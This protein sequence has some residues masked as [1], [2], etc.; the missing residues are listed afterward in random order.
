M[1]VKS[2]LKLAHPRKR[3]A[4]DIAESGPGWILLR[5]FEALDRAGIRYCMLH[6]YESYPQRIGSDVDC[7]IDAKTAPE[8][9]YT[10]LHQNRGRIGAE[11]VRCRGYHIVLAGKNADGSPVF[12][13][14]DLSPDC[15]LDDVRFYAGSEVLA[16][17]RRY[18]EF[19]IPAADIEFGCYLARTIAKANLDDERARRLSKLYGQDPTRCQQQAARFWGAPNTEII[20]AAAQSNDWKEVRQRLA[21]LR[22]ELLRRAILRHLGRFVGNKARGLIDR[23]K[24]VWQPAGLNVVL[25]GPDGAGKSSIIDALAPML[26]GVFPRTTCSGFA[27]A[28]HRLLRRGPRRTDQPHALPARSFMTSVLRAGYWFVYYSFS[29]LNIRLSLARSTLVLNDRHFVDIF[30]DRKRYRYGGPVSLIRLIWRMIPQPDLI[31]VLDAPPEVL[32]ARKREVSFEETAWQCNA[33][34]SLA[35]TL[36]NCRVVEADQSLERVAADV[37]EIILRHLTMR[38]AR[39]FRLDQN[40]P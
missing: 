29:Y 24:H 28:L 19:W 36:K 35:R 26:R 21:S 32:Q 38:I 40:V 2:T 37:S 31:I 10:M 5:V 22:E 16:C 3:L 14:L 33:Y 7:I 6:G 8:R 12:L 11:I 23:A 17:R 34:Q 27:P 4:E 30:V 1:Q 13:T 39:R 15:E 20:V 9:I 25:L 18:R